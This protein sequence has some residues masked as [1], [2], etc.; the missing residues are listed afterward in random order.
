MKRI[1][2]SLINVGFLLGI[3]FC[4]GACVSDKKIAKSYVHKMANKV[5]NPW[6]TGYL[7]GFNQGPNGEINYM[8]PI[9]WK[10]VTDVIHNA[11]LPNPDG[12]LDVAQNSV[13]PVNRKAA[14]KIAH[15]AGVP[16]L[17][18]IMGGMDRYQ[19]LVDS[20]KLRAVLIQNL[21][22]VMDEGYDGL[23]I[24][25]EPIVAWGKEDNSGYEAFINEL[26]AAM[27][28]KK[29]PLLKRPMLTIAAGYRES[30]V[31]ARLQDKLD[32]INLMAYDQ[33]GT[34]QDIT[35]HDSALYDGG[36]KYPSSGKPVISVD[37]AV[38]AC[39]NAG[40][41]ASK[42][43]MGISLE[44]R[45]WIGGSGTDTGGV[46]KPLQTWTTAPKHF[47]TASGVPQDSYSGLLDKYYK[48]ENAHWDDKA[49]VP[50]LSI[51]KPGSAE[52]MFISYNDE[53]SVAEKIKYMQEMGM[54]GLMLWT[55]EKDYRPSQPA[56]QRRPIMQAIRQ[57]LK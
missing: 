27:Q 55:L 19:P 39:L 4:V 15:D 6:V 29:T 37:Y 54:G 28:A 36:Y 42:L 34:M 38:T 12:S 44:T 21:L 49:K 32:Q 50:Y 17:F 40:V 35:W 18:G 24:D 33:S 23:D 52:D 5:K 43:G 46:S 25:F 2:K 48:P 7:P 9:D 41:P 51:D 53:R 56:G 45:L 8:E 3:A 26:H 10:T 13:G 57:S 31:L 47:M 14:I 22:T 20:P 1:V 11:A 16:I 30:K